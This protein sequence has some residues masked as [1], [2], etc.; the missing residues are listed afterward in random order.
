VKEGITEEGIIIEFN[1]DGSVEAFKSKIPSN[2][3]R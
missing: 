2:F 3:G 1:E